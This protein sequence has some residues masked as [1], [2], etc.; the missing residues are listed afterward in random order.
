MTK[1]EFIKAVAERMNTTQKQTEEF[2]YA[3]GE[4]IK[5]ALSEGDSIDFTGY[6]KFYVKL[7]PERLGKSP[8]NGE[9][10]VIPETNVPAFRP[11]KILKDAVN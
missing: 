5:A 7:R 11:G 1:S 3:A 8:Q 2:V 9:V 6:G 10:I 4:V